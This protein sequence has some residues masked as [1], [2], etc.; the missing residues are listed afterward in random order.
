M[1]NMTADVRFAPLTWV[2]LYALSGIPV[3]T[4][5]L[6]VNKLASFDLLVWEGPTQPAAGTIDG[7]PV[8]Y[9]GAVRIRAGAT[10]CWAYWPNS[11]TAAQSRVCVQE[12][13][14]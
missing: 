14:A 11:A 3:G 6:I 2:D 10:G 4:A 1:A 5:L 13:V 12:W 9:P 8:R 7:I